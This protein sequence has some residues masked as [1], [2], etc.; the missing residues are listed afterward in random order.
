MKKI[1]SL[2]LLFTLV[3]IFTACG[4]NTKKSIIG[5]WYNADNAYLE[6]LSDNTHFIGN[7]LEPDDIYRSG[8]W[9]YLEKEE[10]F[11][12]TDNIESSFLKIEI[13]SDK[14][15]TYIEYGEYGKFYKD[16]YPRTL[17]EKDLE[18]QEANKVID[19]PNFIGKTIQEIE[20][21]KE[22]IDNFDFE[23][24]WKHNAEFDAGIVFEQSV[25]EGK[26]LK[27]GSHITL[28][29]SMGQS[30][31]LIP[32]VCGR[33]ETHARNL[34]ETE[35]FKVKIIFI[36]DKNVEKNLVVKTF[37]EVGMTVPSGSEI[38]IYVSK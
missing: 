38:T 35:G 10:L 16:E 11:K 18:A 37:P 26:K 23:M 17:I 29:I 20:E 5:K 3:F 30:K 27:K 7:T 24:K 33:T 32:N 1:I 36:E 34:L 4:D 25:S 28:Y 15:G 13:K 31:K 14:Y 22:Y 9:K 21:N 8:E 6:V 2:F 12:F 19:C